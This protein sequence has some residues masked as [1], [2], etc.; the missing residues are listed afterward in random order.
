MVKMLQQWFST[1][2]KPTHRGSRL[3]MPSMV[4][5]YARMHFVMLCTCGG[6]A[7]K[8]HEHS[9]NYLM[10]LCTWGT[11]AGKDHMNTFHAF[12]MLCT[13]GKHAG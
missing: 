10:M 13:L 3:S 7:N 9:V 8:L 11:W 2:V 6:W 1:P 5:R 4:S 12:G